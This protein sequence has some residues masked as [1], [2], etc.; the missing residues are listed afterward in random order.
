[1]RHEAVAERP[2]GSSVEFL[3]LLLTARLTPDSC[4]ET[5]VESS[6]Q[7]PLGHARGVGQRAALAAPRPAARARRRAAVARYRAARIYGGVL[8]EQ[9]R[10]NAGDVKG[11][12]EEN[13]AQ[14]S[15]N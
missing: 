14:E 8:S 4:D 9:R 2:G 12:V 15:K 3:R 6:L 7:L 11:A 5:G 13:Y 10:Y 1:M